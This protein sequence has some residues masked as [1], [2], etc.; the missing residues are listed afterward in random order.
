MS[1]SSEAQLRKIIATVP[2]PGKGQDAIS[3]E[4]LQQV[5]HEDGAVKLTLYY[6]DENPSQKAKY[7]AI[8]EWE[9]SKLDGVESVQIFSTTLAP[10]GSASKPPAGPH[11]AEP[12]LIDAQTKAQRAAQQ[13]DA[14]GDPPQPQ[15]QRQ[16]PKTI[17]IPGVRKVIAVASGKGGVGK[18][19]VASSLAIALAQ[20]EGLKV[21]LLDADL[22]GPSIPMMF[23][24]KGQLMQSPSGKI[25]PLEKYGVRLCSIGFALNE[26]T[27]V[28]WR[29]LM[30][31]KMIR[32]FLLG[33]EWGELDYLILD[34]PPG[35]GDTQLT[36]VQTVDV[37]GAILVTTP[38][39]VALLDV[40]KGYEMFR[41]TNVPVV[42]LIENMSGYV[43]PECGH[44]EYLFSQGGGERIAD[45][46]GIPYLGHVPINVGI[47]RGGDSG[48]PYIFRNPD[49]PEAKAFGKIA[50]KLEETTSKTASH[51]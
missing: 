14:H 9:L 47:M 35:T 20:R 18:S 2:I 38:Q 33:V 25:V 39:D 12:K 15:Q 22:F 10:A 29:G 27:P 41:T 50:E 1:Q 44:L 24:V 3:L 8:V 37:H 30:V 46:R 16:Q 26:D 49:S 34:L 40:R 23:G 5:K 13:Q 32:Q 11:Q 19:T 31:M 6:S 51:R 45:E 4:M 7:E 21:G 43:C 42:G 17:P 48:E 28:I 36:L